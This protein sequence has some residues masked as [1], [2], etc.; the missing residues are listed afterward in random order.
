MTGQVRSAPETG[1]ADREKWYARSPAA[2]AEAVGVDPGTGLS[3][4]AAAERRIA[5]YRVGA[6]R[7]TPQAA[8]CS[9]CRS[10]RR[11]TRGKWLRAYCS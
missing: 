1:G 3:S 9:P 11:Q 10:A 8:A 4:A 6:R 5:R 7:R 2:V